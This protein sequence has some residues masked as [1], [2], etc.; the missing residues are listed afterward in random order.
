MDKKQ[1]LQLRLNKIGFID[2]KDL[3]NMYEAS[4]IEWN[5][6]KESVEHFADSLVSKFYLDK[7]RSSSR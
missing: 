6:E 2:Q 4:I 1:L 7:A 3:L 5:P